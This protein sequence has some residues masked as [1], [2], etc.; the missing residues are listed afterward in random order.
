MYRTILVPLDG[1][2]FSERALT[3]GNRATARS[4]QAP[5]AS[6][7]F[8]LPAHR[9]CPARIRPTYRVDS[10][11]KRTCSSLLMP[12]VPGGPLHKSGLS[13]KLSDTCEGIAGRLAEQGLQAKIAVPYAAAAKGILTEIDVQN[14]DLVIMCTH[15]RS[16]VG[17][18][19]YGSVAEEVLARSPVPVLLVRPTG[20]PVSLS[21]EPGHSRLLVSLDGSAFAESALPH[22]AGLAHA[23]GGSILLVYAVA[24][25]VHPYNEML[26][27]PADIDKDMDRLVEEEQERAEHY[28][29]SVGER[30]V[31]GG[32][33]VE[34]VVCKGRLPT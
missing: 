22:A 12:G 30:L 6:C 7:S 18:W 17:R 2:S 25:P 24:Q 29:A 23:L 32:L 11:R 20:S 27:I 34:T 5:Q 1:S 19:I 15:G 13:T 16:G 4:Q 33:S 28:L 9:F 3:S 31:Q 14:A 21:A 10:S 26:A 8:A